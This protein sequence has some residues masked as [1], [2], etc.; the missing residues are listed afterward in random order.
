M[1]ERT[2]GQTQPCSG[3]DSFFNRQMTDT[4]IAD[5]YKRRDAGEL[6]CNP[7]TS[8]QYYAH[9]TIPGSYSYEK[10]W[11]DRRNPAIKSY[12]AT[13]TLQVL[14]DPLRFYSPS[15]YTDN[16]IDVALSWARSRAA[17]SNFDA[18]VDQSTL[19]G[20]HTNISAKLAGGMTQSLVTLAEMPKTVKM[21]K[22]AISVL[23][24]PFIA[25]KKHLKLSRRDIR[26]NKALRTKYLDTA[27]NL[28]MEA[29]F[30]WRP[31]VYDAIGHAEALEKAF[32]IRQTAR[33]TYPAYEESNTLSGIQY[34]SPYWNSGRCSVGWEIN[35][36]IQSFYKLGQ[37]GDM[38]VD[39]G[40]FQHFGVLDP[41]G[42]AWE[43]IP[44]SWMVDYFLNIG[45][46]LMSLQAY[47]LLDERVGWTTQNVVAT[48]EY[49]SSPILTSYW[50]TY[51][52]SENFL[53]VQKLAGFESLKIKERVPVGSFLPSLRSSIDL[54]WMQVADVSAVLRSF[55]KDF[56]GPPRRRG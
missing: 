40:N 16:P 7:M 49:S 33:G 6:F 36:M 25:A 13:R 39:W 8:G 3:L 42:T 24:H 17:D 19:D 12:I 43:L 22:D 52:H 54:D 53:E 15:G 37:T 26:E 4:E 30:G 48:A 5:F 35:Y 23:R 27:Q 45:D 55:A 44:L 9:N 20:I 1:T 46:I 51:E 56:F 18:A 21:I 41:L 10:W 50:F 38:R 28:W 2:R 31:T 14:P 32:T 34:G 11:H 47:A 29:R